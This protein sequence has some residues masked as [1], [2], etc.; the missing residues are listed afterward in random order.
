MFRSGFLTCSD[1][2]FTML[3]SGFLICSNPDF[4]L[5]VRIFNQASS[6]IQYS[7]SDNPVQVSG[8]VN[9]EVDIIRLG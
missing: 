4:F 2:D 8:T 7:G 1:P 6:R 5:Q 3:R 9:S